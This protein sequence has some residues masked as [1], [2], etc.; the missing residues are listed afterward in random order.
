MKKREVVTEFC[1]LSQE[2][3]E[4][5]FNM[6]V[7]AD[8]ICDNGKCDVFSPEVMPYIQ[9]A[10]WKKVE[11]DLSNTLLHP[12]KPTE[13]ACIA[14]LV[15]GKEILMTAHYTDDEMEFRNT[16]LEHAADGERWRRKMPI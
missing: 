14:I 4:Q 5:V 8:C 13:G 7:S 11:E 1:K 2:V 10:V 15:K 6:Q 9:T 16:G 3:M 12:E